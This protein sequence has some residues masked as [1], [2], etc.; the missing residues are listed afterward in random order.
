[1]DDHAATQHQRARFHRQILVL[2]IMVLAIL[3]SVSDAF[4]FEGCRA[5][6][7]HQGPVTVE[8]YRSRAEAFVKD[9]QVDVEDGVAVCRPSPGGDIYLQASRWKWEP[10]LILKKGHTYTL[11]LS[12]T[13]VSHGFRF[14]PLDLNLLVVPGEEQVLDLTPNESGDFRIVCDEFCGPGHELMV[15]KIVVEE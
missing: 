13:D 10:A 1:M 5:K 8:E 11:H 6:P 12:S 4:V 14:D 3:H 15:G 9:T 7:H 2:G